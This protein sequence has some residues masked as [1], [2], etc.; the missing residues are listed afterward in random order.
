M[1]RLTAPL[2]SLKAS[3]TIAKALTFSSWKGISYA[4]TRVIPYNPKSTDQTEVRGIFSTL[5][6][7]Y[8]RMPTFARNPFI[9][10]VRG[11]PLTA[12]NKHV[13]VNVPALKGESDLNKLIMSISGGQAVP[14]VNVVETDAGAQVINITADAPTT[15]PG[16]TLGSIHAAAVL[17]GD[18]S[19]V[20]IRTTYVGYHQAAPYSIDIDVGT[21]GTYQTGCWC[22]FTRDSDGL[23][24]MSAAVRDQVVVV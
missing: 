23:I 16:Y 13:Q 11:L 9:F 17:D 1:A 8:K 5:A 15:P 4:R 21:A 10:A 24:F 2:F 19:P 18:P 6:E 22:V 14:P 12:R 20:I 7:M 3:G